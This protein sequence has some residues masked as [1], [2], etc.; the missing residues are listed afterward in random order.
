[1][2]KYAELIAQGKPV[3]PYSLQCKV[4]SLCPVFKGAY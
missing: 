3:H 1:M 2:K 4:V